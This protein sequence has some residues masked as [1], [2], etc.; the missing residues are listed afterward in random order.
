MRI[1]FRFV[2]INLRK[3]CSEDKKM[4]GVESKKRGGE[5]NL[6]TDLIAVCINEGLLRVVFNSA[7]SM[8]KPLRRKEALMRVMMNKMRIKGIL[9]RVALFR[10]RAFA[11]CAR[12]RLRRLPVCVFS[13]GRKRT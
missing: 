2:R 1:K 9:L 5:I 13:T 10:A 12:L 3:V 8:I 11:V 7:R 4:R 6:R